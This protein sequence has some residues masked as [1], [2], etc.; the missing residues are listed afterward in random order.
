[1]A[2][3]RILGAVVGIALGAGVSGVAVSGFTLVGGCSGMLV[4]C[5]MKRVIRMSARID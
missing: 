2:F 4:L 1:M 3:G 5:T